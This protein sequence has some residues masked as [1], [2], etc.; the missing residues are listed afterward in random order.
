MSLATGVCASDALRDEADSLFRSEKYTEAFSIYY[1][2][3]EGG[4]VSA[5][6]LLK[7]A[8]IQDASGN[9]A[10]ALYYLDLYYQQSADRLV[11]GKIEELAEEYELTGYSYDDTHY[12]TALLNRFKAQIVFFLI[13]IAAV[14]LIYIVLKAR[15]GTR[16]FIPAF[17]QVITLVLLLAAMNF[18][19]PVRAII[20]NDQALLRSGPSAGAEPVEMVGRGHK[21]TVL[22]QSDIW[23]RIVWNGEEA[24]VR[25][26][27]LKII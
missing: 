13:S 6:M 22:S 24:F 17:F 11:V 23:S 18:S 2:M 12:F 1:E 7:M 15:K 20:V 26:S 8:F 19:P 21:V 25:N 3:M 27:R 4:T 9:Y 16:S 14:L 5:S 10:D